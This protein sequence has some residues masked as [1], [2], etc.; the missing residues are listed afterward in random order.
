MKISLGPLQYFWPKQQVFDFY[1]S[2]VNTSVDIVY[3][4]ETVCSKRRELTLPDWLDIARL[5]QD[6]GKEVV[7]STMVLLEAE[8]EL[9]TMRKIIHNNEFIIEANDIAAINLLENGQ[10]FIIGQHINVYN[11]ETL[12]FLARSGAKRW[13]APVELSRNTLLDI[14]NKHP[15]PIEVEVFSF[16]KLPLAYSARCFT[17]RADNKCKD[18]CELRCLDYPDGQ[19]MRTLEGSDFLTINGIQLQSANHHNLLN[20]IE[21][22]GE[23][24]ISCLRISPQLENTIAVINL[25]RQVIY[26]DANLVTAQKTITTYASQGVCNGYWFGDPGMD[27]HI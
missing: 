8:S 24:N 21:D 5:L 6:S 26:Q 18:T 4:G 10:P 12:C 20:S 2:I 16:G 15:W 3:L 19:L 1:E 13:C 22:L 7:L 17:A 11:Q 14:K 9:I 23:L 25:F 27:N